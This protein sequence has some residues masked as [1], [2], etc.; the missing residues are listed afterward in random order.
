MAKASNKEPEAKPAVLAE[1]P[2]ADVGMSQHQVYI[3]GYV[4]ARQYRALAS[5]GGG[6]NGSM[7]VFAKAGGKLKNIHIV[8]CILETIADA[9]DEATPVSV[10]AG[11]SE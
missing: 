9:M 1:F 4:T 11:A 7:G 8:R 2:I 6:L 10:A 3:E 5:I